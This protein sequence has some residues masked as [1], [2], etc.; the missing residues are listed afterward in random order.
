MHAYWFYV[1]V[2]IRNTLKIRTIGVILPSKNIRKCEKNWRNMDNPS[3][4]AVVSEF[5]SNS[6]AQHMSIISRMQF[7]WELFRQHTR[8]LYFTR[9]WVKKL[10]Q[11]KQDRENWP[12][13]LHPKTMRPTLNTTL[14]SLA[15][16][17]HHTVKLIQKVTT[18]SFYKRILS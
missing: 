9:W 17:C 10:D 13:T 15:M 6:C 8:F 1:C 12:E 3:D 16:G 18:R 7:W 5:C 11:Q 4:C 14:Q 2:D